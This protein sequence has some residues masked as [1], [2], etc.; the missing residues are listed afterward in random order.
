MFD[1]K[2]SSSYRWRMSTDRCDFVHSEAIREASKAC[3]KSLEDVVD[4]HRALYTC[5]CV[6]CGAEISIFWP[7]CPA[8]GTVRD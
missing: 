6:G 4:R 7:M 5:T 3:L 8:C 1:W 2:R